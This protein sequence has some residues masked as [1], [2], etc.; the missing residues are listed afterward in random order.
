MESCPVWCT[1]QYTGDEKND[2][3]FNSV[4]AQALCALKKTKDHGSIICRMQTKGF[5][6]FL[7]KNAAVT[8]AVLPCPTTASHS[9]DLIMVY[10]EKS[11]MVP[12]HFLC[13]VNLQKDVSEEFSI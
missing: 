10:L 4:S 11:P 7:K 6:H 5:L 3:L 2:N 1:V 13:P 8:K 9:N 12:H